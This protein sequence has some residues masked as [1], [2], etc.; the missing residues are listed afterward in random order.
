[1]V[2]ETTLK[3]FT[4]VESMAGVLRFTDKSGGVDAL[5]LPVAQ[6]LRGG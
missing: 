6:G 1:M 5:L 2:R 3:D 4:F